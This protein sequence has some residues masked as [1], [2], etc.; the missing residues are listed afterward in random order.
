MSNAI[1]PNDLTLKQLLSLYASRP[2]AGERASAL[3]SGSA[4]KTHEAFS[5]RGRHG[6]GASAMMC[7]PGVEQSLSSLLIR[8][9]DRIE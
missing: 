1:N 3:A 4:E 5:S 2:R 6:S 8:V 9:V 7:S